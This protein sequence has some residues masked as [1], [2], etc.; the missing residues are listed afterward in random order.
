MR[1]DGELLA[2]FTA[3]ENDH[4]LERIP[5]PAVL[6]QKFRRDRRA[7]IKRIQLRDVDFLVLGAED[8][9]E[10]TL[11]RQAPHERE[12]TAFKVCAFTRALTTSARAF[13]TTTGGFTLARR[14]TATNAGLLRARTGSGL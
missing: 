2:Q 6:R 8:I 3:T 10:A 5:N 12:L 14:N 11:E 1:T 9:V 4:R 13:G 7:S